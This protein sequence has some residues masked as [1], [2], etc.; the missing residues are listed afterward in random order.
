VQM[1][2]LF[3]A[4]CCQYFGTCIEILLLVYHYWHKDLV[5][6]PSLEHWEAVFI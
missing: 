3:A 5:I 4:I 1:P 2:T 6:V